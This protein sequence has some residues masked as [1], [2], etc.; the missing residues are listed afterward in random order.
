MKRR[1]PKLT[2]TKNSV[3]GT[4]KNHTIE[5]SPMYDFRSQLPLDNEYYVSIQGKDGLYA[6]SGS[7]KKRN[8]Y[9]VLEEALKGSL[10]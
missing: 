8:I 6:Y 2:I 10:L 1:F 9:D 7:I 3:S 5:I 4:Y